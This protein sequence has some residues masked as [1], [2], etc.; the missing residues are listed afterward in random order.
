MAFG[1]NRLL[2]GSLRRQL[3]V[4]VALVHAV[5]M[6]LFVWDLVGRQKQVILDRQKEHSLA[7]ANSIAVSSAGWVASSDLNGLQEIIVSQ[8]RYPELKYAMITLRDGKV[9]AHT[10][11][12]KVGKYVYQDLPDRPAV[13]Q[14]LRAGDLVESI[15]PVSIAGTHLGWVRVALGQTAAEAKIKSVIVDGILYAIGAI[16]IGSIL[17]WFLGNW[18]THRLRKIES[19]AKRIMEGD[20]KARVQVGGNDE[21]TAFAE[22][23]NQMM[24]TIDETHTRIKNISQRLQVANEASRTGTWEYNVQAQ[25]LVWDEWINELYGFDDRGF[26]GSFDLWRASVH[27]DD[28]EKA[29]GALNDAI[30]NRE[31][32]SHLFRIVHSSGE[33]RWIKG[34]GII[35]ED[36]SGAVRMVGTNQDVTSEVLDKNKLLSTNEALI[37]ANQKANLAS[38]AKSQFLATMSHELRTPLNAVL[39]L[40]E[41]LSDDQ[42]NPEQREEV[43]TIISSGETLLSIIN[44]ILDFSQ[45][46]AHKFKIELNSFPLRDPFRDVFKLLKYTAEKKEIRLE[47]NIDEECPE[48]VVSDIS[49]IKQV[50]FNL[51]GNAI[52]F[53]EDGYVRIDVSG[54][55]EGEN[56]LLEFS[57][58]D[59]G[60][61]ISV[62]NHDSIF[63]PFTQA[64]NSISRKFGGTGLGLAISSMIVERLGGVIDYES[65]LGEGS[66]FFVKLPVRIEKAANAA[67]RHDSPLP[68]LPEIYTQGKIL[69]VEDVKTNIKVVRGMLKSTRYEVSSAFNGKEALELLEDESFDVILMDCEMP[70]MNGFETTRE[71]RRREASSGEKVPIVAMTAH[72]L[73]SIHESMR[74]SGMDDYILKPLS[75]HELIRKLHY[76]CLHKEAERA[77]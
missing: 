10:D 55:C 48:Y 26:S 66:R 42:L 1:S 37:E 30:A 49:R 68:L 57:V 61:G 60:V 29:E 54:E 12:S 6:T 13:L 24:D 20:E 2:G 27:P 46:D 22:L 3:I 8:S 23:F 11:T 31:T 25:T 41:V 34:H 76:W 62:E 28:L 51:V 65:A 71:I 36:D 17:A 56:L 59:S 73:Y 5:L 21:I 70:V 50:L 77:T 52:K 44:D 35:V 63:Q 40:A 32:Y 64:D 9:V 7:L 18:F 4:S 74:E 16:L 15:T 67:L 43:E 38:E 45:L 39:G 75:K 53:T 58:E 19:S 33:I 69:V 72:A 47:L 14:V